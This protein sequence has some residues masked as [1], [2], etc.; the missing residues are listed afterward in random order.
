VLRDEE[1]TTM[2]NL[3][4]MLRESADAAP[5]KPVALF[6]GGQLTYAE[7]DAL[8]DRLAAGLQRR[9]VTPGDTVG[10]QLPNVPQF[11]VAYF[12]ILKAGAVAVPMNILL[13][14]PEVAFV[15]EDSATRL[16]VTWAGVLEDAAKAAAQAG[17]GDVFVVGGPGDQAAAPPF[18]RLLETSPADRPL[19][20]TEPTDTAVVIYTS[21]TT[22]RPKGAELTHFQL[23]MNA[24]IPGRLFGIRE[25]DVVLTALPLFHVFGLSSIVNVSVRFGCTMSLVPRFDP[26]TVL[27]AIERHRITIF[28]GVPTMYVAVLG[29][30]DL[31]DYDVSSLRVGISGGAALPAQVLD[32]FER[33]FG[34]VIL[35][36]YGMSET[37]STTTFNRSETERRAYSVGKPIWGTETQVW[38]EAGRQLPPGRDNVGELVTRGF[39]VMRGYRN[40]PDATAEAFAGG[41]L[42]TGDLGY[43]DEDGFLFIVDRKKELII[44]GGYNVYPREVE[45][46]LYAHPGVA[47][48]AVV[49]LPDE[50]LGEE[51]A[52]F[53]AVKPG[54]SPTGEELI[55]HCK[56]R[57]AA[58]K[59]PRRIEFRD[60]LPR[61]ASG[62]I[63]KSMLTLR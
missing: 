24:D 29:H 44:R 47:E 55:A 10:V 42:H 21:G 3:A 15:L 17:V 7:L 20:A 5:T 31:D 33:R 52:A 53:V 50:R 25:D 2:L 59:Y 11:L 12:G 30:P 18:E 41:W 19:A 36:G 28:E 22:G 62:K 43:A 35:E 1:A 16:L 49:G 37:A 34:V 9:G 39:H 8:S 63:V 26:A 40:N 14:A 51:V 23:Y 32:A 58:Y 60:T 56:E 54:W 27:A 4:V 13:K 38:D 45:E 46:A 61:N 6:D 57:V 48:A